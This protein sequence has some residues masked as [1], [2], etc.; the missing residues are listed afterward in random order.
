[1]LFGRGA[2]KEEASVSEYVRRT[3]PSSDPVQDLERILA[4]WLESAPAASANARLGDFMD[5]FSSDWHVAWRKGTADQVRA[6]FSECAATDF[7]TGGRGSHSVYGLDGPYAQRGNITL[8]TIPDFWKRYG[9][10]GSVIEIGVA[11]ALHVVG[12][13]SATEFF[14]LA[15]S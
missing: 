12:R 6:W 3:P 13:A 11:G 7:R 9:V 2:S 15:H 1:M 5:E 8:D 4:L 14:Y 10:V